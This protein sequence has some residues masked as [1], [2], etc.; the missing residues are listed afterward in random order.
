VWHVDAG[1]AIDQHSDSDLG[2]EAD[3]SASAWDPTTKSIWV[4]HS[5][6]TVSQIQIAST[7][8]EPSV[9][10]TDTASS[11]ADAAQSLAG[12]P[13]PVCRPTSIPGTFGGGYD[14]AW[15]F[16]QERT[17]GEGCGRAPGAQYIGVGTAGGVDLLSP[18]TTPVMGLDR[19]WWSPY[20][21]PDIDGD[22]IDE[23]MVATTYS[24]SDWAIQVWLYRVG[25]DQIS[26]VNESCG[27]DCVYG[28]NTALGAGAEENGDTLLTGLY[29]GQLESA[30]ELG[31]GLVQWQ[32]SSGEPTKIYATVWTLDGGVLSPKDTEY[33][34][35]G[36]GNY[37]PTGEHSLCGDATNQPATS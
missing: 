27:G 37:P 20:A 21:T 13:F 26:P 32:L 8:S 7:A 28:W 36:P 14:V 30:P 19:A 11:D 1:G 16:A 34:S 9:P 18:G 10:A 5:D 22:G 12:V 33:Q 31:S 25:N 15:T 29:C 3:G 23:I 4:V 17:P 24:T 2:P 6:R 35:Q